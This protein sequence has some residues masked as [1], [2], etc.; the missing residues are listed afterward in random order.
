MHEEAEPG[1]I[2]EDLSARLA[3]RPTY[4]LRGAA[5]TR[6]ETATVQVTPRRDTHV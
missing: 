6:A 5:G 3:S 1:D 4:A 2:Q